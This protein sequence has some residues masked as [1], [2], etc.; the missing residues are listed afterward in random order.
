M[1]SEPLSVVLP[2]HLPTRDL[3]H[4]VNHSVPA[5]VAAQAR[6]PGRGF[7]VGLRRST[8]GRLGSL[9]RRVAAEMKVGREMACFES[10]AV[11][12]VNCFAQEAAQV[13]TRQHPMDR[14]ASL[15]NKP[16]EQFDTEV[17]VIDS[18]RSDADRRQFEL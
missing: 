8:V 15:D 10:Q 4:H 17:A 2:E 1:L 16:T 9:R 12:V 11:A 3:Q 14:S 7:V 13:L 6:F 5:S 18:G